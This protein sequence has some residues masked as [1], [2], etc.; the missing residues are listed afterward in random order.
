MVVEFNPERLVKS[1]EER[2]IVNERL[3]DFKYSTLTA[4]EV[5]KLSSLCKEG[6][7]DNAFAFKL[8]YLMF[9]KSYPNITF[10]QFLN[11]GADGAEIARLIINDMDFLASSLDKQ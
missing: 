2:T 6:D 1:I 10:E 11:M 4:I 9:S 7:D 5:M 8:A 3:G